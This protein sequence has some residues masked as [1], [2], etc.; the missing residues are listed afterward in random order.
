MVFPLYHCS[1]TFFLI[2]SAILSCSS[3]SAKIAER[4]CVPVS[5]PCRLRVVGSCILKKNSQSCLY[6][7]RSGSKTISSD[8]AWPVRPEQTSAYDG[9]LVWP[10]MYPTL[11]SKRPLPSPKVLRYNSSRPQKH[12][13]AKMALCEL[14]GNCM[15]ARASGWRDI[16][17]AELKGRRKRERNDGIWKAMV[18]KRTSARMV[19][20]ETSVMLSCSLATTL[21]HKSEEGLE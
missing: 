19:R 3:F 14:G 13:P 5:A 11:Q 15:A 12:P 21:E 2:S 1:P 8:S 4:Y 17:A 10:P 16:E 6:E 9:A 20:G 18:S 7:R